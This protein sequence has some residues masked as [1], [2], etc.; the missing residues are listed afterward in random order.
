MERAV[1]EQVEGQ[2]ADVARIES[3]KFASSQLCNLTS[4]K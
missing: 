3:S 1:I 4:N 2:I